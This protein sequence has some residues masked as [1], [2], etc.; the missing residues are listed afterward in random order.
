M[1]L[2]SKRVE[3]III[4]MLALPNMCTSTTLR[5]AYRPKTSID[6]LDD[7]GDLV[8]GE[9]RKNKKSFFLLKVLKTGYIP[10]VS[11]KST[12]EKAL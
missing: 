4:S 6:S 2:S 9:W 12:R 8:K 10:T 3:N 11:A 7:G 5:N 1:P